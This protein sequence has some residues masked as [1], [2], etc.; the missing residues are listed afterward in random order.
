MVFHLPGGAIMKY[1]LALLGLI[2]L[3]PPA[4]AASD[5]KIIS[6]SIVSRGKKRAFYL[7]VPASVRAERPA[8][9][10][11]M[12]HGSG[13][14][15]RILVEKWKELAEKEGIILV[16][17][18]SSDPRRWRVPEDGPDFIHELVETLKAKCPVNARRIYLFGHSAGAI[19]SIYMSLLESRYFAA[20][21]LHAGALKMGKLERALMESAPRKIPFIMFVG[22]DDPFFPLKEVRATRDALR[23]S[24]FPV[25]LTEIKWHTHDYYRR[26]VEINKSAWEFL[27]RQKL[28]DEPEYRQYNFSYENP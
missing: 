3:L 25:E 22:T 2:L 21:A 26:S 12:L 23:A 4:Y 27:S 5:D 10:L 11:V 19:S 24:G 9:L 7:Y 6:D 16:G 17:P 14:S 1:V 20:T 28:E 15:G 8:P 13:Q 18:E